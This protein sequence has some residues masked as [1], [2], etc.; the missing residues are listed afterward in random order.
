MNF[1]T[2]QGETRKKG[3]TG[4][5]QR[6]ANEKVRVGNEMESGYDIIPTPI[7]KGMD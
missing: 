5:G 4:N 2:V 1:L 6:R 7:E 3:E